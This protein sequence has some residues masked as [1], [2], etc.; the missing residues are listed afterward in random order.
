MSKE[1]VQMDPAYILKL[2]VTVFS[3]LMAA[4]LSAVTALTPP[5]AAATTRQVTNRVTVNLMMY[6]GSISTF[7]L[8]LTSLLISRTPPSCRISQYRSGWAWYTCR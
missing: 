4:I 5:R 8:V 7:S 6:A 3:Q 1:K 2:A